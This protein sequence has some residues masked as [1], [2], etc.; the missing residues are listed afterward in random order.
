MA[1]ARALA[2]A[3]AMRVIDRV[4][5]HA[6]DRRADAEPALAARLADDDVLVVRVADRAHGGQAL[7]RHDAQLARIELDLGVTRILADEL[8]IGAG[9]ARE[10]PAAALLHLDIV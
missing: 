4:H 7:A 1:S 9:R 10:L 2:L 8:G 3:A 6:T 5:G